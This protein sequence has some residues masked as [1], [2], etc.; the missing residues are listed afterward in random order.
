[1]TRF[2]RFT[3]RTKLSLVVMAITCG[4]LLVAGAAFISYDIYSFRGASVRDVQTLARVVASSSTAALAFDD[5][6]AARDVL[7]QL[8]YREHVAAACLYDAAD[9]PVASYLQDKRTCASSAPPL[10]ADGA[11]FTKDLLV[12]SQQIVL[13]GKVIG[14]VTIASDLTELSD[15]IRWDLEFY[16]ITLAILLVGAVAAAARL[17]RSISGPIRSLAWTAKSISANKD[18]SMRAE[19]NTGGEVGVL[20]DGFN[21]MLAEIG[22]RDRELLHAQDDLEVRVRERTAE[23]QQEISARELTEAAL[24]TSDERTRLLLDSTAEAIYGLD[25]EGRC[26]FCN[27][28]ALRMLGY[29][30][31]TELFGR[32]MHELAHHSHADG[33]AYPESECWMMEA[34]L[35]ATPVHVDSEVLWRSD[36][37]SFPAEYWAYP[38]RR[39]DQVVGSV[40][41]FL[42]ISVRRA[43][44][45]ALNE[46]TL[47]LSSLVENSP[48]AILALNRENTGEMCN[49]AFEKLFG[50]SSAE[51]K[52]KTLAELTKMG[53]DTAEGV[54][55]VQQGLHGQSVHL[56]TEQR[57]RDGTKVA[58]ELYTVP[59]MVDDQMRG[60]YVIYQ[61]ISER[62][63]ASRIKDAQHGITQVLAESAS[64]AE[65]TS[66]ILRAICEASGWELG[67]L[68]QVR[69]EENALRLVDLWRAPGSVLSKDVEVLR[70][71]AFPPGV[72]LAGRAWQSGKV[73]RAYDLQ[74]HEDA[75]S[76]DLARKMGI[77]GGFA[78]PITSKKE[79]VGVLE[80]FSA[81][82]CN[83]DLELL[84]VI[85][86]LS[87]QIGEFMAR[88]RA[89]EES[90]RFFSVSLD[91][92]IISGLDG[93]VRRASPA[94]EKTLGFT[95]EEMMALKLS[96]LVHAEDAAIAHQRF[97]GLAR[98][99]SVHGYEVRTRCKDGSY[100]W[101]LWNVVPDV[102]AGLIYC[103]GRD[104]TERRAAEEA[105]QSAT[106]AAQAA[107]RAKSE[108]LA[109]MSHEIRTPMNGIIGMTE[110]ALGTQLDDEP[111]EYL[112][113][114]QS[115][116]EGLL[117]I[118]NDILDFS[119]IEAGRFDLETADFDLRDLLDQTLK[120]LSVRAHKKGLELSIRV[121]PGV[122]E[123]VA[124]DSVRLGQ[125]LAN[126]VGNAI[127]FTEKGNVVVDVEPEEGG[128]DPFALHF[129]VR[130]SGIGIAAEKLALVF[131]A[132]A[133]ADG[134]TTRLFGGTG[135]GLTISRRI[136]Q[137][138]G[139]RLQVES[140]LE[141]GSTFYFTA[142]FKAAAEALAPGPATDA[143]QL[144][145]V[146][147]LVADDNKTN[148]LIL[149]EML[150][151]WQMRPRLAESGAFAL[152][153]LREARDAGRGLPLVLLDSHMP[154]MDGFAVA[155][156][157]KDEP[158]L[159]GVTIMMLTSDQQP[160]DAARCRSLGINVCVVKP[161][162]RTAL[163]NAILTALGR[164]PASAIAYPMTTAIATCG[165]HQANAH[166]VLRVLLA[167][168]N[169]VNRRL[170]V[171][172]LEKRGHLVA[173]A[174]NGQEAID[175]LELRGL[176]AFDAVLMD[177]Q[178]PVLDGL[179]ATAAIRAREVAL[180][181]HLPIIGVT[182]HAREEDRKRC[183]EAGMDGYVTKPIRSTEL[184]AELDHLVPGK[185]AGQHPRS[186]S[187]E[188]SPLKPA[189]NSTSS[190]APISPQRAGKS[191]GEITTGTSRGTSR[192]QG[193]A[194][195]GP[196]DRV[197]LLERVEGDEE[198]LG[199]IVRLFLDELPRALEDL[200]TAEK[201]RDL[202]ALGRAAHKLRGAL[203]NLCAAPA[204]AA[205]FDLER[206]ADENDVTAWRGGLAALRAEID[207]LKA[208]LEAT[209][210]E[211][212]R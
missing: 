22:R 94:F 155:A 211:V 186:L 191:G 179:R 13:D 165:E 86:S 148:R 116:A 57:R 212:V 41:T 187:A 143:R 126:L 204:T 139:G 19:R 100:K 196:F 16:G 171:R 1:M 32:N 3:I 15:V 193:A 81:E 37:T 85:T 27:S 82:R 62:V 90:L 80:F 114:V 49:P 38:V 178:M 133:Q 152:A 10:Q 184:F 160:G 98:G 47:S 182:A 132:F 189:Q 102:G 161:I 209:K 199:E 164:A 135:L 60:G 109:N 48:L 157:I 70:K 35:C 67:L 51:L 71:S 141:K 138:M 107:S 45:E 99:I 181:S 95:T 97:E 46:R 65:A 58:V 210:Q 149:E 43:N 21:E 68:A 6:Q 119:K 31:A 183:L 124:G 166:R 73:M 63:R 56:T 129:S 194:P 136:V 105:L 123:L 130:D 167:E 112:Q 18:F 2:S 17:Q 64:L 168:D 55:V 75:F 89:E 128:A 163:L 34:A 162:G 153:V 30:D 113:M 151:N 169:E 40:V 108:F 172:L 88:K 190:A 115:S 200:D 36:G 78:V 185:R 59:L 156:L 25:L 9:K 118:V 144:A 96:D 77:H 14:E 205:A 11:H 137:M 7:T 72:G 127:K 122:P 12:V 69:P 66:G 8:H 195:E 50:F 91:M 140:E 83:P 208:P 39:N 150:K 84:G 92:L 180:R 159:A 101:I 121:A 54:A 176:D 202:E 106:D 203:G 5:P 28:A 201:T 26:T 87:G 207:R 134:T 146:S 177:I 131:E 20:I 188:I 42:D 4:S 120:P 103:A 104:V 61:D 170:V 79:V 174:C 23:L 74:A 173:V 117:R 24:R 44:E 29:G 52:G 110:L 33:R 158:G 145:G 175:M 53:G 111:R 198:L 93:C 192:E 206:Y 197:A 142:R 76:A 125:I 154:G 147:V